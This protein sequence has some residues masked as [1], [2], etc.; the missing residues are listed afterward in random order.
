ML[1]YKQSSYKNR[2]GKEYVRQN[3]VGNSFIFDV[4]DFPL[5]MYNIFSDGIYIYFYSRK[6]GSAE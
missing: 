2:E 4:T 3:C 1:I 5:K 6:E